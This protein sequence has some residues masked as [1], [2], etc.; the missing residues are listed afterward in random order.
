MSYIRPLEDNKYRKSDESLYAFLSGPFE[1]AEEAPNDYIIES[2]DDLH[3][4]EHFVE[5][6][7]RILD[8]ADVSLTLEEV[9]K[10]RK[11]LQ[12]DELDQIKEGGYK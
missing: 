10:L 6:V 11:E 4:P 9:N 12:L 5:I 8:R 2:Y 7:C 3:K 1:D